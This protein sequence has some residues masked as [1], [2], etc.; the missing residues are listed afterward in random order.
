VKTTVSSRGQ[1]VLPAE[2]REQDEI[3]AGQRFEVER[4]ARGE[5]RLVRTTGPRNAGLVDLL[6][7]CPV[8]GWFVPLDRDET[9]DDVEEPRLG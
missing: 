8:K 6:L 9:T 2:L 4:I 7:D 3:E 1:I 5:Y